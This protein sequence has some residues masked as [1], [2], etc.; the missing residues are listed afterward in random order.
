MTI[1][2]KN[3]SQT[4]G[5]KLLVLRFSSILNNKMIKKAIIQ[6]IQIGIQ[7]YDTYIDRFGN[8]HNSNGN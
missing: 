2:N 1:R 3:R 7:V 4:K 5:E 8:S 6:L